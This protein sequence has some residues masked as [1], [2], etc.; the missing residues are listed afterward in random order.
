MN[1]ASN[2]SPEITYPRMKMTWIIMDKANWLTMPAGDRSWS[3]VW[4]KSIPN[5]LKSKLFSLATEFS[6]TRSKNVDN[7][8]NI[9]VSRVELRH[10]ANFSYFCDHSWPWSQDVDDSYLWSWIRH[11]CCETAQPSSWPSQEPNYLVASFINCSM[12]D[13]SMIC[14]VRS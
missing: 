8:D 5:W 12:S 11:H 4:S 7:V 6:E 2:V 13:L 9:L 14:K 1:I 10:W 3:N